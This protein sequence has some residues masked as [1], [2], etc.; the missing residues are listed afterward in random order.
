MTNDINNEIT[1][2]AP[3]INNGTEISDGKTET[4][5]QP[6]SDNGD[7]IIEITDGE[8]DEILNES[9]VDYVLPE[10][11]FSH[12]KNLG[13]DESMIAAVTETFKNYAIKKLKA[14]ETTAEKVNLEIDEYIAKS[15]AHA[16]YLKTFESAKQR[17][18]DY[19]KKNGKE[20]LDRVKNN[21][22]KL[23]GDGAYDKINLVAPEIAI[24]IYNDIVSKKSSSGVVKLSTPIDAPK[25]EP[26]IPANYVIE[27]VDKD[28]STFLDK[29]GKAK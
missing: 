24:K 16:E 11:I 15:T 18:I 10:K 6:L 26:Y 25:R 4:S 1:N 7:T 20:K 5:L 13:H 9:E 28:M 3:Q 21:V 27:K 8:N 12:Y 17:F 14:G 2:S 22:D 19:E 23:L 29:Y